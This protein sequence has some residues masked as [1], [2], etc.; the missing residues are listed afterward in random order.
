MPYISLKMSAHCCRLCSQSEDKIKKEEYRE[1]VRHYLDSAGHASADMRFRPT[2]S[3]EDYYFLVK[4]ILTCLDLC[5]A[6]EGEK[7][8][9]YDYLNKHL[10]LAYELGVEAVLKDIKKEEAAFRRRCQKGRAG[11][12]IDLNVERERRQEEE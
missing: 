5:L 4:S 6:C 8:I 10:I 11:K 1:E 9:V 7:S 3:E 12:I 2:G